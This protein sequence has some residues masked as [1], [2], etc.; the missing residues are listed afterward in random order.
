[1][2]IQQHHKYKNCSFCSRKLTDENL[3]HCCLEFNHPIWRIKMLN[4]RLHLRQ[5]SV[6]GFKSLDNFHSDFEPTLTICQNGA[7]K[8]TILQILLFIQA[9]MS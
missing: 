3:P 6:H 8:S 9:F 4:N 1:M 7:G 5:L 2:L